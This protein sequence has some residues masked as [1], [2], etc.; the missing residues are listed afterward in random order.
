VE[1][2]RIS[3]G[4]KL[5]LAFLSLSLPGFCGPSSSSFGFSMAESILQHLVEDTVYIDDDGKSASANIKVSGDESS[6]LNS[7]QTAQFSTSFDLCQVMEL[8]EAVRL[9]DVYHEVFG[10]L[11]PFLDMITLRRQANILWGT[12]QP[13]PSS[14][15]TRFPPNQNTH[16]VKLAIAI[17]LLCE[18]GGCHPTA[19]AIY[20]SLQSIVVQSI[21][22]ISFEL[23]RLVLLVLI[24]WIS[25]SRFNDNAK[26]HR[27]FIIGTRVTTD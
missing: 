1:D 20:Q 13:V 15:R 11:H 5:G 3:D 23:G 24:V 14:Q 9:L 12:L 21:L 26:H 27:E 2:G 25:S 8:E 22:G 7:E 6:Y 16:V 18:S 17:A 10:V 4:G 19:T